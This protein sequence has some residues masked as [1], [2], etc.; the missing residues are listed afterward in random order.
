[1]AEI[2]MFMKYRCL[3]V[4]QSIDCHST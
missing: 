1:M 2:M 4:Q 3:K